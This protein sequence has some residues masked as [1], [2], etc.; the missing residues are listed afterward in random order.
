M[1]DLAELK[2]Q[3]ATGSA[4]EV[5]RVLDTL[6]AEQPGNDNFYYLRGTAYY[7]QGEWQAALNDYLEA[8]AINP[9]S[10]A[11]EAHA[12]LMDILEFYNKDIYN[13]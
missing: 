5:I 1:A 10:P 3:I 13:Q 11:T 4:A 7:K 2:E 6:L 9:E 8:M 12:M